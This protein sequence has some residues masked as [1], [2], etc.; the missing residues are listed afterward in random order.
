[1][2][3]LFSILALSGI[4]LFSCENSSNEQAEKQLK[5][6]ADSLLKELMNAHDEVMPQTLVLENLK[7]K[8]LSKMDSME[9]DSPAL[10]E[11][12]MTINTMDTAIIGMRE[13]MSAFERP[14]DTTTLKNVVKY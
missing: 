7:K 1:M 6:K 4:L 9:I 13:W 2:K 10:D 3:Y 5:M 8:M 11:I 12:G 14:S